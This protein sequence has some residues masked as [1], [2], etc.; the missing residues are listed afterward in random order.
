MVSWLPRKEWTG[1]LQTSDCRHVWYRF[2]S[3]HRVW[4][5]QI[6]PCSA[7]GS[8][9]FAPCRVKNN[10]EC[11]TPSAFSS[12]NRITPV[13][14]QN[15]T[16]GMD[17]SRRNTDRASIVGGLCDH[18]SDTIRSHCIRYVVEQVMDPNTHCNSYTKRSYCSYRPFRRKV[19]R[20]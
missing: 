8:S 17:I 12:I 1:H 13:L 11:K 20:A 6:S 4:E 14:T 2:H 19:D 10:P 16:V 7:K 18:W 5:C 3:L 9:K 15:I